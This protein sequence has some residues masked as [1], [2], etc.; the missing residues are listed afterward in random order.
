MSLDFLNYVLA[1]I[2]G[3]G[4]PQCYSDAYL[5]SPET[6][7]GTQRHRAQLGFDMFWPSDGVEVWG[8]AAVAVLRAVE[9]LAV[10]FPPSAPSCSAKGRWVLS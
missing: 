3:A 7:I 10:G 5:L 6:E 8:P 4:A 1:Q 9:V 2:A